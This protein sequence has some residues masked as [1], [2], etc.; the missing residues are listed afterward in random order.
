MSA[1]IELS[2]FTENTVANGDVDIYYRD[3]GPSDGDPILLVQGL[4]GQLINWPEHL[5]DF[6][7]DNN[8]RP[9]V[10]DN[11]DTGKSSRI[12][13]SRLSEGN[14]GKTI[15]ATKYCLLSP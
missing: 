11:R 12:V 1:S 15:N 9:I 10:F 8:F 14:R 3:Y 2:S 4:G 5:I 7:I 6:L 13:D